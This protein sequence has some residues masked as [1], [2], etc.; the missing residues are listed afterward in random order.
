[1]SGEKESVEAAFNWYDPV[2]WSVIAFFVMGSLGRILVSSDPFDPRKFAGEMILAIIGAIIIYSF[3]LMQGMSPVQII[4][5]GS[6]A[7]LG[8]VRIIEWAI[9]FSQQVKKSGS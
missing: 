6:L 4:F 1:M 9:K 7:S 8:G 3:N 2:L 5:L